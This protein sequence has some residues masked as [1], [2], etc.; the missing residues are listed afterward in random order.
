MLLLA[1]PPKA[2]VAA[3]IATGYFES[4]HFPEVSEMS[5]EQAINTLDATGMLR[6]LGIASDFAGE[7][8]RA[9]RPVHLFILRS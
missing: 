4:S 3:W 1:R 8:I 7:S 9:D 6:S 5:Q 2:F